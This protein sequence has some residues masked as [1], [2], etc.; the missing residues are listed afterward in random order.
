MESAR[1]LDHV[2][3]K[4]FIL[5]GNATFTLVSKKT[6]VRFTYSV[7]SQD[8]KPAF[9]SVLSG[10][11]NE[12][13]FTYVGCIFRQIEFRLTKKSRFTSVTPCVRAF[14]WFWYNLSKGQLP[15][16]VEF[17]HEGCCARCGRKLTVPESVSS[18]FGPECAKKLSFLK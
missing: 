10:S 13:D 9:V 1:L 15:E 18:G 5:A 8:G 7:R 6:G 14:S 17:W 3:V 11:D 4:Q 2:S 12:S 16:Q